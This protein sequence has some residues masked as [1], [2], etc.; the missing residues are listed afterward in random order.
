[1]SKSPVPPPPDGAAA[2]ST[3]RAMSDGNQ[4]GTD[5]ALPGVRAQL[6]ATEHWS[7]LA[8]RST[9]QGELLSSITRAI[10]PGYQRPSSSCYGP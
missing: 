2:P 8:T 6:L 4:P 5:G 3:G 10:D 1:M 7:L 9:A